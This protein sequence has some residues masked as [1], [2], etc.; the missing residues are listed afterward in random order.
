M[1]NLYHVTSVPRLKNILKDGLEIHGQPLSTENILA[2]HGRKLEE[3]KELFEEEFEDCSAI[4]EQDLNELLDR[5]DNIFFWGS[6]DQA[7]H[8]AR[9]IKP[10][11]IQPLA[12]IEVD[13]HSI[14]CKCTKGDANIGDELHDDLLAVCYGD[15]YIPEEELEK[16]ADKYI[17]STSKYTPCEFIGGFEVYCPCNIEPDAIVGVYDML[18]KKKALKHSKR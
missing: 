1:G 6:L 14:E 13:S 12:V 11:I 16:R 9:S 3:A 7:L 8:A 17:E 10:H 18:G 2:E 15:R 5:N 4:A